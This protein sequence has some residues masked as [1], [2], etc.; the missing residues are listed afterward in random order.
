LA[1]YRVGQAAVGFIVCAIAAYVSVRF[2]VRWF[3]TKTPA[4]SRFKAPPR[5]CLGPCAPGGIAG[6]GPPG[7]R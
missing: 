1:A 7:W 3:Q 5:R 2:L 6:A 4:S